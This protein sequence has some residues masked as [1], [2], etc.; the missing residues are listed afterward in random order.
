MANNSVNP[1]L[2]GQTKFGKNAANSGRRG[3]EIAPLRVRE[4]F[5]ITAN[6]P[7]AGVAIIVDAPME[8]IAVQEA[9][10]V[11]GGAAA[12]LSVEKLT[13]TQAPGGGVAT[14]VGTISLTNTV[15]TVQSATLSATPAN[16]KFATGDRIVLTLGGTLTGLVGA[17]VILLRRI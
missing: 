10:S 17:V 12:V 8:L 2:R 7:A 9:H 6:S 14:M 11:V 1:S 13:G 16:L 3:G 5:I 15:N 4:S